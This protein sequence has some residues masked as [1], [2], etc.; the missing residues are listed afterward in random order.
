MRSRRRLASVHE[1]TCLLLSGLLGNRTLSLR[2]LDAVRAW[3]RGPVDEFWFTDET[4]RLH[5]ARPWQRRS[6]ELEAEA[7]ASAWL[8]SQPLPLAPLYV[9]TT[10]VLAQ[11]GRRQRPHARWAVA[12]DATPALTDRLRARALGEPASLARR[13]FRR[14][15]GARFRRFAHDVDLW[16]PMSEACRDSLVR[17]YGV[18]PAHCLV[19][20]A[21]QPDV[22]VAMSKRDVDERPWRLL[23]VGNDFTRKGGP[24]L[25]AAMKQLP[26]AHLTIVS[27]APEAY[28][29]AATLPGEQVTVH[30]GITDPRE[31]APLYRRAHLLV[32]P[33]R[34]DHYSHVICEG[35]ARGL[36]FAVTAGTP[37]AELVERS[38]AG[39][40]IAW[41]PAPDAIASAVRAV[42][43]DPAR[44]YARRTAPAGPG[45]PG[46][47]P[48]GPIG[49][50]GGFAAPGAGRGPA[51]GAARKPAVAA[52]EVGP[53]A[54]RVG[55]A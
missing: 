48:P 25:C 26:E 34:L 38:G 27:R 51:A 39:V 6:D 35:L 37:P 30:G 24:E 52:A 47:G 16:L 19:T 18:D 3:D 29:H 10:V 23:F 15:Q 43:G 20:S 55:P 28:V 5:P 2:V 8:R 53:V 4:Y 45:G 17:D 36:P 32:H 14:V 50:G 49:R 31:L 54:A 41:P 13:A 11:V 40:A 7:V 12:T 46:S 22:D 44:Y 1:R 21:P 33:T 9:A 42:L